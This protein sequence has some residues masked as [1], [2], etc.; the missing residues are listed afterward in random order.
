MEEDGFHGIRLRALLDTAVDGIVIMDANGSIITFNP[1]CVRLFGF[2]S[3]EVIGRNV[4]ML[5]PPNYANEHDRYLNNYKETG[6]ARII[7]IGREV[8][9]QRK[10][11]T[12]F[13]VRLSVGEAF[14]EGE[15]IFVGILSDLTV[16]RETEERLQ[17]SQRL[18]AIGQLTGGIAHDFNNLLA[19]I[20]GNLEL[21]LDAPEANEKL[22]NYAQEAMGASERGAELVRRLLAF[23]RKQRLEPRALNLNERLPEIVQML[24]R[25]IGESIKI[26]I[27]ADA[28]LWDAL[29]DP[30]QVDD[31]IVNL[32]INA[33]DAM[34]SGGV[35]TI[36]TSNVF[37]DDAYAQ[38]HIELNSGEY[39]M[40][41]VT[42]TG[43][44]MSPDL[45]ARALEPFFTTKPAGMGTGLGLSQVYGF[46]KQSGGH[47]SIYSEL[48]HGTTVKL[49]LPRSLPTARIMAP[50]QT[51]DGLPPRGTERLLVVEDNDDIRR[52]VQRQLAELGYDVHTVSNG[53]EA[54]SYL[55]STL[56]LELLFTDVVMPDGMS[57]Y[58]LAALAREI[59][60]DLKVAFTSGY[61]ALGATQNLYGE[62]QGPLLSKPYRKVELARFIRSALDQRV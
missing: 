7:G 60:P 51:D 42:D 24:G 13:P 58:E 52:L 15:S 35:L 48:G 43:T 28:D 31:A 50:E 59:R 61:T 19:I 39:V 34:P 55:R 21:V 23:A 1:A 47:V 56:A 5:M 33:R 6:E 46:V 44:G 12:T 8:F 18:E 11:G 45:A 27:C 4:K 20:L 62:A 37:L 9:A 3:E 38:D 2:Q 29:A 22:R 41:A 14:Q 36:E 40:L 17:R 49:Y 57:G 30:N 10:D 54:L 32:S 16:T 26:Q 53:P 25:T